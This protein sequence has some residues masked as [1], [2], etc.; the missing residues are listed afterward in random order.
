[1]FPASMCPSVHLPPVFP[2]FLPFYLPSFLPLFTLVFLSSCHVIGFHFICLWLDISTGI[3]SFL[4]CVGG[5]GL[6]F[7]HSLLPH[8][9][10]L[11]LLLSVLRTGCSWVLLCCLS[12]R[13]EEVQTKLLTAAFVGF[14]LLFYNFVQSPKL[15]FI[16]ANWDISVP[17]AGD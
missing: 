15:E 12:G 10:S 11:C 5:G 3:S 8:L 16:M 4:E 2:F 7:I 13:K 9:R 14:L 17:P 1:M 6:V